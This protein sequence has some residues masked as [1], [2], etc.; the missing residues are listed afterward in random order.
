MT[1]S[2]EEARA[3]WEV[4]LR[5]VDA[6]LK[7]SAREAR[8]ASKSID[9]LNSLREQYVARLGDQPDP[10]VAFSDHQRELLHVAL[11]KHGTV[12]GRQAF[13]EYQHNDAH[14]RPMGEAH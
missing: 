3:F 1:V 5:D 9:E 12:E 2:F 10:Y 13:A 7:R 4:H 11:T 8:V 6:A 14:P